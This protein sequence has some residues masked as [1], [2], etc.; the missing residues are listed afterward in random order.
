MLA[1]LGGPLP[2]SKKCSVS[3]SLRTMTWRDVRT[4]RRSGM[5]GSLTDLTH[6]AADEA[7]HSLTDRGDTEDGSKPML[8]HIRRPL[9]PRPPRRA[10]RG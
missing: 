4:R 1:Q 10:V 6:D 9:Y 2:R 3:A 5:N 8:V 7:L